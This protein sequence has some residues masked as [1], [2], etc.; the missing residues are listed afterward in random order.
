A[1]DYARLLAL[2]GY[3]LEMAPAG[4]GWLGAVPVAETANGLA[5]GQG[6]YFQGGPPRSSPVPFNTPL[7]DAGIDSGDIIKTIDGQPATSSTWAGIGNKK[8]GDQVTL[9]VMR[10][11][12]ELVTKTITLKQDPTARQVVSM[13]NLSPAQKAFRDAWLASKVR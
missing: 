2:A 5:A 9:T 8:P 13:P 7:Y 6:V 10:R 4:R 3:S 11:G 1:P 12:G